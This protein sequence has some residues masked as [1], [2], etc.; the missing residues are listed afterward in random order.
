MRS[1]L[2]SFFIGALTLGLVS[3]AL[4]EGPAVSKINGKI[5][6]IGGNVNG[7]NAKAAA[8]SLTVP[9][10][11]RFGL[12]IDTA[13]GEI[14]DVDIKGAGLHLFTR[15]PENFLLGINSIYA[16]VEELN[17]EQYAIEGEYYLGSMTLAALVG[18]Q[19]G[20]INDTTFAKTDIRWYPIEDLMFEA[21]GAFSDNDN[22]KGHI[23]AEYQFIDN[24]SI[25]ADIASGENDY[26]HALLGARYY[27]G[28]AKTLVKRHREDD[29]I[30]NVLVSAIE[31]LVAL[32][33]AP[34][35]AAECATSI[36]SGIYSFDFGLS[37]ALG[38]CSFAAE[39]DCNG[40]I[41]SIP[42]ATSVTAISDPTIYNGQSIDSF[43]RG[44]FPGCPGIN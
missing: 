33:S 9:L 37:H 8:V 20:D 18:Y 13:F 7:E 22:N 38:G 31:G 27:L 24:V 43:E 1:T 3:I 2:L 26:D 5:E 30:N 42:D 44:L 32:N 23:G 34:A 41:Q 15:D 16:E 17:L 29:P 40:I 6:G 14:D 36:T 12:Q 10:G 28:A 39:V 11:N 25:F 21:G 19:G 4:A 35:A